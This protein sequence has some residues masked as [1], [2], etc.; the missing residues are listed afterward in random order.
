MSLTFENSILPLLLFGVFAV[1]F[2]FFYFLDFV[3]FMNRD[4]YVE[5]ER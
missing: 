3:Y 2:L 1:N 5:D 4:D